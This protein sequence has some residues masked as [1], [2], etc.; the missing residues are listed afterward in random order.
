MFFL[1][2]IYS[3]FGLDA[4][5]TTSSPNALA[6]SRSHGNDSHYFP[7]GVHGYHIKRGLGE[8]GE[9]EREEKESRYE[10]TGVRWE[11]I[12]IE[13]DGVTERERNE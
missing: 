11:K 12:K 4:H 3:I 6:R 9:K 8:W 13:R 5:L 7:L 1:S 2:Y 10:R